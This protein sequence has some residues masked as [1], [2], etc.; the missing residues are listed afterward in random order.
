MTA[1]A[2]EVETLTVTVDPDGSTSTSND[3]A[4]VNAYVFWPYLTEPL[5]FQRHHHLEQQPTEGG[6]PVR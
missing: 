6:H 1:L 3:L 2:T 5:R 4:P